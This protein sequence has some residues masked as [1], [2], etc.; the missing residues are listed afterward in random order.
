[1]TLAVNVDVVIP[2]EIA[3]AGLGVAEAQVEYSGTA[4]GVVDTE[5]ELTTAA[6]SD[7]VFSGGDQRGSDTPAAKPW[8]YVQTVQLRAVRVEASYLRGGAAVP[9]QFTRAG[10]R[11]TQPGDQ[12]RAQPQ[13]LAVK[14]PGVRLGR[15]RRHRLL[16]P[17]DVAGLARAYLHA[18]DCTAHGDMDASENAC[19]YQVPDM[20][21]SGRFRL[22]PQLL[23]GQRDG[24]ASR[25]G[26]CRECGRQDAVGG[27]R[28]KRVPVDQDD[29]APLGE[30]SGLDRG[31]ARGHKK[32]L[33][34]RRGSAGRC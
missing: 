20:A 4:I 3:A 19:R 18:A 7:G 32:G 2:V 12:E 15:P 9:P 8:A 28:G 17:F 11:L 31:P 27:P 14:A 26:R 24:R 30:L 22:Q 34:R 10:R 6:P 13:L 5:P 25:L 33:R 23:S 16:Q 29:P 1:M 21:V